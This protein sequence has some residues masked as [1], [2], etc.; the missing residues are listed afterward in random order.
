MPI[1]QNVLENVVCE[2]SFIL[3]WHQYAEYLSSASAYMRQ[4]IGSALVQILACR[5]Y[6]A[7]PL[8]KPMLLFVNWTLGNKL[9]ENFNQNTNIF[10]HKNVF[11]II[12]CELAAIL[13]T[14]RWVEVNWNAQVEYF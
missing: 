13:S 4:W 6:G 14:G 5:L 3:V 9:Q 8:S 11:E 10:I 2:M 1:P 12:V 7:E